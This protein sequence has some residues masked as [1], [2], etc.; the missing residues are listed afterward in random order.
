MSFRLWEVRKEPLRRVSDDLIERAG[1]L[2]EMRRGRHDHELAFHLQSLLRLAVKRNDRVIMAPD[3]E[4]RRRAHALERVTRQI[5]ASAARDDRE[6]AAIVR[7]GHKRRARSCAR[8][9]ITNGQPCGLRLFAGPGGRQR[10]PRR[11]QRNVEDVA[12]TELLIGRE[13]IEKKRRQAGFAE[14]LRDIIVARAK[15][16]AAAAMRE[17]D[18]SPRVFGAPSSPLSA[19]APIIT[20]W[21]IHAHRSQAEGISLGRAVRTPGRQGRHRMR[22]LEPHIGV[23]LFREDC[24]EIMAQVFGVGPVDDADRPLE[25]R[26]T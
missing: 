10:K 20:S 2:E 21:G 15:P 5:R 4:K 3:D 24:L 16:A 14:R 17:D 12:A 11:Q 22:L 6:D 1:F 25:Q 19:R 26:L 7:C 23:E 13:K 9:E 18:E 8:P